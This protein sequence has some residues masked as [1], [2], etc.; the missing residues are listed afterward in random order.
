M[1]GKVVESPRIVMGHL[2]DDDLE[3]IW[4]REAYRR[5][6]QYFT[7]RV[8]AYE[9]CMQGISPDLDGL[10]RLEKAATR[11]DVLYRQQLPPPPACRGCPYL[12]GF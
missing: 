4:Q 11:L 2:A 10:Q 8:A 12:D 7:K 5:F 3:T 1:A 6:R 9:T